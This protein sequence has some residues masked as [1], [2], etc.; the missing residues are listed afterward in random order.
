MITPGLGL[1][2][3]MTL[4][5]ATLMF[6]LAKFAWKPILNALNERETSIVDALNQAKLAREEVQNLKAENERIIQEARIEKDNILR[7]AREVKDRI[8]NEAKDIAKAEG[9]KM[10]ETA[11]HSIAMEKAAAVE[12]MK[13]QIS[14]LSLDIA[15]LILK[16]KLD[17]KDAQNSLV[18]NFLENKNLN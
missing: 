17:N 18:A 6:L 4:T 9:D 3:W 15:E 8:I 11:R 12:E 2:F 16:Q 14:I 10:L 13:N 5:F 1:L 7:E